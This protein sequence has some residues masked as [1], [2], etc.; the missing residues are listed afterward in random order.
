MHAI[1]LSICN[2]KG[3]VGKTTTTMNLAAALAKLGKRVLTIDL[4]PQ[5][6]L[7]HT[8]GFEPDRQP[9]TANELI[10][11]NCYG[12]PCEY[13]RFVRHNEREAVDYIPSTPALSSAPT[14]LATIQDGDQV[15]CRALSDDF[16]QQYD[17]ILLDCKPSLD[18][19]TVNALGAS[20]GLLIPIEP[21]EYAVNGLADLL[22]TVQNVRQKL[23]PRLDITGVLMTRADSRRKS[24]QAIRSDLIEV[25]G[26]KVFDTTIPFLAEASDAAKCRESCVNRRGSRI[27]ELYMEV[28]REV[29]TRV[30]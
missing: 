15:L 5:R 9:T 20:D 6:N 28:A 10:Y 13:E 14:L 16:F 1:T 26:E 2:Q 21:E 19:L 11:F 8:L 30:N 18:L 29:V 17:F 3:G 24:V 22:S 25:L 7:S 4:D 23:N 12:M 27:G